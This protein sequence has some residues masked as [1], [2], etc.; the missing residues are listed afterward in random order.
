MYDGYK[1][2]ADYIES[3]DIK[4]NVKLKFV[5]I[6][7]EDIKKYTAVYDVLKMGYSLPIVTLNGKARFAGGIVFEKLYDE[8]KKLL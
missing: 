5:D 2:L 7:S 6:F 8:V 4:D 1:E 3:T